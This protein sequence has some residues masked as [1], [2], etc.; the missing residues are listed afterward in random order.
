[1]TVSDRARFGLGA[2]AALLVSLSWAG[3]ALAEPTPAER[4]DARAAMAE[5]RSLR[6][7]RNYE[8]AL[9]SFRLADS[10]M[11]VPTTGVEVA[12]TLEAMGRLV[13]ARS[14]LRR[15]LASPASATQP[16]PFHEA[17]A[18]A[19]VLFTELEERL[20]MITF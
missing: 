20:P 4:N 13:E 17:M 12:R 18:T 8:G 10:I 6:S 3:M 11:R 19:A 15:V 9:K 1:M 2:V 14:T 5:G 16:L 7:Q